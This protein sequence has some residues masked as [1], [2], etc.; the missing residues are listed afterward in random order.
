VQC[1]AQVLVAH[2]QRP[3]VLSRG[4][5]RATRDAGA[6][7]VSDGHRVLC[8]VAHAGDEPMLL[9]RA[10]PGVPV[11]VCADRYEAGQLAEARFAPTVHLLDDGF[12][13]VRLWRDIDLL[14]VDDRDLD[15]RVL[16]AGW[17]REPLANAHVAD[18]VLVTTATGRSAENIAGQLR[19]GQAFRVERRLGAAALP[20]T[21]A[22]LTQG[23]PVFAMAGI[24]RPE[25]FFDDL[26]RAG[27]TVAGT[28]TFRDHHRFDASDV[29]ALGA[30]ARACGAEAI[31]T[32]EK[33]AVRLEGLDVSVMPIAAV[34]LAMTIEPAD[35]FAEW[36]LA[37]L[38]LA[39]ST[40]G[41]ASDGRPRTSP[42]PEVRR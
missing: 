30:A 12:Q 28:R 24:A 1:I 15:D 27:W 6:T 42:A 8:D 16:P 3:C 18:A 37:R 2:G 26:R 23:P 40:G 14:M 21:G 13:H 32:T 11:I 7:V 38:A 17:L 22:T 19:V 41:D 36:L 25:R 29:A 4:Y 33:D 20:G 10:L 31:V 35:R 5:G 39:R 9:A 34:P